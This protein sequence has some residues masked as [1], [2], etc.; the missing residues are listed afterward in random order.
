[1][2]AFFQTPLPE[3]LLSLKRKMAE[4][5]GETPCLKM[6]QADKLAELLQSSMDKILVIDSRS[7]LEYNTCHVHNSVNVGSSKLI[8]RRLQQ[9]K[10][11]I[12]ELL[13]SSCKVDADDNCEVIVYDQCT[14]NVSG[15]Q[16]ENFLSVLLNKLSG[17]FRSVSL[18]TG[19]FAD[20]QTCFPNLCE[21]QGTSTKCSALA[22]LSQPCMPVANV[23]PTKILPYLFVG[24]QQDVFDQEL[25]HTIGIEYVLNISKTCPQ[26]QYVQDGHFCRIPVNDNYSEKILPWFDQAIE[27]IDKVQSSNGK[28]IV[29]CLAGVSR[30]ATIAIAY[31][32]KHLRMSSD[33]AYRYVKDK[34]PT[35]SPNFNFLGQLLEF[36]KRLKE[37]NKGADSVITNQPHGGNYGDVITPQPRSPSPYRDTRFIFNKVTSEIVP[38]TSYESDSKPTERKRSKVS[39]VN[40]KNL[41]TLGKACV[42]IPQGRKSPQRPTGLDVFRISDMGPIIPPAPAMAGPGSSPSKTLQESMIINEAT[43]LPGCLSRQDSVTPPLSG[44]VTPVS[45]SLITE[46]PSGKPVSPESLRQV[47]LLTSALSVN[48][49]DIKLQNPFMSKKTRLDRQCISK[50]TQ[51]NQETLEAGKITDYKCSLIKS[52]GSSTDAENPFMNVK[53]AATEHAQCGPIAADARKKNNQT[54]INQSEKPMQQE[55]S[56]DD[57]KAETK[58]LK[59]WSQRTSVGTKKAA[60]C[61]GNKNQDSDRFAGQKGKCKGGHQITTQRYGQTTKKTQHTDCKLRQEKTD[62]GFYRERKPEHLD[63]MENIPCDILGSQPMKCFAFQEAPPWTTNT[64]NQSKGREFVLHEDRGSTL[65]RSSGSLESMECHYPDITTDMD[66]SNGN[67]LSNQRALCGSCEMIEVS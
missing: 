41:D 42:Q 7:F 47:D 34:R 18:L 46:V 59:V 3:R 39:D 17:T 10:V 66:D 15:I 8:K 44:Q 52:F 29:H 57:D 54:T 22:P 37:D 49:P 33:D 56:C 65:Q 23:G 64:S 11:T 19:G 50:E 9:D 13:A 21:S 14:K 2:Q 16:A 53:E 61:D 1:M 51:E 32:M 58:N 27:F 67:T 45:P 30:S 25:M 20:F 28:V 35:I 62:S 60:A 40:M 5:L 38:R 26:P 24:S 63:I 12:R 31:V 6:L 48:S 4:K 55:P 36:E 43:F